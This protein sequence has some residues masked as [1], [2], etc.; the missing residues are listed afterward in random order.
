MEEGNALDHR[1]L[2]RVGE[3]RGEHVRVLTQTV[4]ENYKC[5]GFFLPLTT[6]G[7]KTAPSK[8]PAQKQGSTV[9]VKWQLVTPTGTYVTRATANLALQAVYDAG[10]AGSPAAGAA[11]YSLYTATGGAGAGNSYTYD[12]TANQHVLN[13]GTSSATKGCYDIVYTP[14]NGTAQ[15]VTIVQLK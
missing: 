5:G 9:A 10:C 7:T 1:R 6:A 4:Q 11:T 8:S 13:W 14:D 2:R 15:L 12:T 3:L